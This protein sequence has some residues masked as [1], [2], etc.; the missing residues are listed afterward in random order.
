MTHIKH[1]LL[2]LLLV[3]IIGGFS[4]TSHAQVATIEPDSY[5]NT[6]G[7]LF[8]IIK[9]ANNEILPKAVYPYIPSD[10]TFFMT[11]DMKKAPDVGAVEAAVIYIWKVFT[12]ANQAGSDGRVLWNIA[13]IITFFG[14]MLSGFLTFKAVSQ[15]KKPPGEAL[16]GYL[17]KCCIAIIMLTFVCANIPP[18][19]I[20]ICNSV[21]SSVSTWFARGNSAAEDEDLLRSTFDIKMEAA[22]S[23]SQAMVAKLME[24]LKVQPDDYKNAVAE[25]VADVF[26]PT[27]TNLFITKRESDFQKIAAIH[28]GGGT[29]NQI[30]SEI[31]IMARKKVSDL[32]RTVLETAADTLKS[33][34]DD[35][36]IEQYMTQEIF[37]A[38]QGVDVS[39]F[40]YPDKAIRTYGYMAFAYI[41][42]SIWGIGIASL[43]WV[44]LYALPEEWNMGD[45]LFSGL[46]A[47]FGVVLTVILVTIYMSAATQQVDKSLET[48]SS[49]NRSWMEV[50]YDTGKAAA[51][52][53]FNAAGAVI[54]YASD[55]GALGAKLMG[56]VTGMTL[57]SIFIGMLIFT[58]PAQAA[59][60][61]KGGNGM[62]E[63]AKGAMTNSGM[64]GSGPM[65]VFGMQGQS[66]GARADGNYS[67]D[68]IMRDR[69]SITAALAP[70][71]SK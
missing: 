4:Q 18:A 67:A 39:S 64:G 40:S 5:K 12:G 10:S 68:S 16:V 51:T 48:I 66:S 34:T 70:K 65:S 19:L 47:C 24:S 36:Q 3:L 11:G 37:R 50:L 29:N 13:I 35:E 21:T 1:Y 54:D 71:S 41:G 22:A 55:P 14:L 2:P 20:G 69:G 26:K 28:A 31:S 59:M 62:A 17:V 30:N 7:G 15:G 27:Y 33:M 43:V 52:G 46:K 63:H 56:L 42:L 6:G 49:M 61:I 44:M 53:S 58:A 60:M 8:D 23:S 32:T 9:P 25:A 38:A 45:V 57:Q